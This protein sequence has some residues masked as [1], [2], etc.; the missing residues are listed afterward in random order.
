MHGQVFVMLYAALAHKQFMFRS[1]RIFFFSNHIKTPGA[2]N[3]SKFRKL[4]IIVKTST[5]QVNADYIYKYTVFVL[6]IK[7]EN[8]LHVYFIYLF[9]CYSGMRSTIH[10]FYI[11]LL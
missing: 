5:R 8:P 3:C 11:C 9:I 1:D 4:N 6:L 10:A 2:K 7:C